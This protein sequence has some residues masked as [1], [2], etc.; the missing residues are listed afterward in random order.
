M[1]GQKK[2]R[3]NDFGAIHLILGLLLGFFLGSTVVYWQFNRQNDR[4]IQET[5]EKVL[6]IF[7]E[8]SSDTR[9]IVPGEENDEEPTSGASGKE[10]FN[11]AQSPSLSYK[12]NESP[13]SATN[14]RENYS[15]AR[16]KLIHSRV[17]SVSVPQREKSES[18]RMLD[19]EIGNTT[20]NSN[21]QVFYVEFWESPLNSVGYKMSKTRIV[22]YGIKIFDEAE[23]YHHREIF[24]LRYM[25]DF[26][27]L[28]FTNTFKPLKSPSTPIP[29]EDIQEI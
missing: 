3:N 4:I 6:A 19:S 29:F 22:F 20:N 23:I 2:H 14:E 28:E 8:N 10:L 5:V 26:Y 27:P 25:N 9:L 11:E 18:E 21:E 16:D 12:Q 24:Y 17:I 7:S 15:L 1:R 13:F